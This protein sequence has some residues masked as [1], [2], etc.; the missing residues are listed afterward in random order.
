[1]PATTT[2]AIRSESVPIKCF[3]RA[4]DVSLTGPSPSDPATVRAAAPGGQAWAGL[5]TGNGS[6]PL[7][8][9]QRRDPDAKPPLPQ[10]DKI[11]TATVIRKRDHEY[12]PTK[13]EGKPAAGK[14]P[15][16]GKKPAVPGKSTKPGGKAAG[17]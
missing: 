2:T 14:T 17:K 12:Q 13:V 7:A 10:P 9:L 5:R 3:V 8:K 16:P 15:E 6:I 11:L 4:V 1:M